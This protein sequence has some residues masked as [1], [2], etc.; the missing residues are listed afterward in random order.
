M[1]VGSLNVG[2]TERNV[3]HLARALDRTR[4]AVRVWCAYRGQPIEEQ[5][6][7]AGVPCESLKELSVG[8]HPLVR[9]AAYNL[10]FQ[11]RLARVLSRYRNGA[12]LSFGFPMSYYVAIL[13]RLVGVRR[14]F[15]TVQDW[16]VWKRDRVY[17]WLDTLC[18]RLAMGVICDGSGAREL[19]VRS[20][21]MAAE[22]MITMYDGVDTEELKPTRPREE[23]RRSLRLARD[24]PA[25]AVIA[26]LDVKKKGQDCF[27]EAIPLILEAGV[28]AQ[29]LLVGDGPDRQALRR[30]CRGLPRAAQPIFA[31]SRM[32]LG[33]VLNAV[34]IL[35][36][37]SLWESVPK[38]LLEGMWREKPIIATR[39]GDIGE[40]LDDQCG[41]LI[42]PRDPQALATAV[43]RLAADPALRTSLGKRARATIVRRGLTLDSTVKRYEELLARV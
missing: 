16:D 23:T 17:R 33:D 12:V 26:R 21:Q 6:R 19:A 22:K 14:V 27:L 11:F 15:F 25:V 31:G 32:D 2:G 40:V 29:F 24:K 42:P 3:L 30:M 4:F 18:S 20:Q 38:I 7:A 13:G 28:A 43:C 34:D 5:I 9:L 36:I 8:R 41:L 39:V 10:P 37:P 1:F 35:V